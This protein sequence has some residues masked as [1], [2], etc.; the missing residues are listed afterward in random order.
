MEGFP[1][2]TIIALYF[3]GHI[4][5]ALNDIRSKLN[6]A[7]GF[8]LIFR[9]APGDLVEWCIGAILLDTGYNLNHVWKTMLSFLDPIINFSGLQFNPMRELQE[10]CQSHNTE[11]EFA[12]SKG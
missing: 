3:L 2:Q 5:V 12:S 10:F 11:L 6:S 9:S 1:E 7:L 8:D 4:R